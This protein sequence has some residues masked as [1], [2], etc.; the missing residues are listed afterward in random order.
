M[1]RPWPTSSLRLFL[2]QIGHRHRDVAAALAVEQEQEAKPA[3]PVQAQHVSRPVVLPA[4][5]LDDLEHPLPDLLVGLQAE[6]VLD[7]GE[8]EGVQD[9][10]SD[11]AA[12]RQLTV[13]VG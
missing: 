11:V 7:V 3:G 10:D 4:P 1:A 5:V 2:P 8:G 12:L 9:E 6:L 13:E